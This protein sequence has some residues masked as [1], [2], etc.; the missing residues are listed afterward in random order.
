MESFSCKKGK[1]SLIPQMD[2]WKYKNSKITKKKKE[3]K[4]MKKMRHKNNQLIKLTMLKQSDGMSTFI[5]AK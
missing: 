5:K 2:S 4:N 3:I 1:V